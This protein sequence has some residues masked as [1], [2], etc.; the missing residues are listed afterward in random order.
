MKSA[1][2]AVHRCARAAVGQACVRHV[3][4]GQTRHQA[5][6]VVSERTH[7]CA[8]CVE[9]QHVFARALEHGNQYSYIKPAH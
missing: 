6:G 1:H 9:K 8:Q 7:A 2:M 3:P 4:Q 5:T